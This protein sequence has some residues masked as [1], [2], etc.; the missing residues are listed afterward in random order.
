VGGSER[1]EFSPQLCKMLYVA[2]KRE[3]RG[4][5][6]RQL[7]SRGKW[8]K[9]KKKRG[10]KGKAYSQKHAKFMETPKKKGRKETLPKIRPSLE[11]GKKEGGKCV[12]QLWEKNC[13][14]HL[15]GKKRGAKSR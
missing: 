10:K 8:E 12:L 7:N 1:K 14:C 6:N 11:R 5:K 13:H 3:K 4:G 2:Q 9:K 15:K